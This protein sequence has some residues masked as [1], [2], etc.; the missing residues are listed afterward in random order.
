MIFGQMRR[1][2]KLSLPPLSSA[3][4]GNYHLAVTRKYAYQ[5]LWGSSTPGAWGGDHSEVVLGTRISFGV[6]GAV[7]GARFY[8]DNGDSAEHLALL[9][10]GWSVGTVLATARF[11]P[12]T[13][14]N[15][16]GDNKWHNAYFPREKKVAA[17]DE[18][19]IAVW[20]AGG[21]YWRQASGLAS[22]PVTVGDLTAIQ[23]GD[24]GPN[25]IYTLGN[26]WDLHLTFGSGFYGIDVLFRADSEVNP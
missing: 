13:A 26:G 25:G 22:G 7:V 23:D 1:S 5:S 19:V 16:P 24:G 12:V 17:A 9:M 2:V 20:F 21:N 18:L 4:R 10:D 15:I 14:S 8:Q 6:D 3:L 11:K